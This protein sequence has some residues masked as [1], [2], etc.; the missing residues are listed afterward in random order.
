MNNRF[1]SYIER[2]RFLEQQNLVLEAQLRQL[3]VKY[4]SQLDDLYSSEVRR[5]KSFLDA[6]KTDRALIETEVE[7][8]QSD[9]GDLKSE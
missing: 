7:Q 2:V 4:E 8:M 1:A 6:L 9:V 3:S 5:L